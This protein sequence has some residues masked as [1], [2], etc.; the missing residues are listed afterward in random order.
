MLSI[1]YDLSET[2]DYELLSTP[3]FVHGGEDND[4]LRIQKICQYLE[5]NYRGEVRLEYLAALVGMTPTSFS[6]YFS[7]HAGKGVSEYI[8]DVR[9]GHAAQLLLENKLTVAE[10]CYDCGFNTISHFNRSFKKHKG[11]T[12]TEF[13]EN[14]LHLHTVP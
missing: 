12:P 2:D 14:Y 6:R 13:R 1:L 9:L 5:R 11:C 4:S 7:S 3:A 8:I 10:I